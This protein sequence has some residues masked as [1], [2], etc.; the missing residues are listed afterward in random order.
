M[1]HTQK[2]TILV[3][4]DDP[5][6][7]EVLRYFLSC[8]GY[9]VR[10]AADFVEF[11]SLITSS[12]P[13]LVL[14]DLN[15]PDGDGLMCALSY[16]IKL[17]AS[18]PIIAITADDTPE[19][20]TRVFEAGADDYV[21][22]PIM[23]AELLARVQAQLKVSVLYKGLYAVLNDLDTGVL[24]IDNLGDVIF[25]NW[26]A[27]SILDTSKLPKNR[28][29][30]LL[31]KDIPQIH[32][33]LEWALNPESEKSQK[34]YTRMETAEN[35]KHLVIE[36]KRSRINLVGGASTMY[37][38]DQTELVS[39]MARLA[40][41]N[42]LLGTSHAMKQV[43]ES[44]VQLAQ[45][46]W[47]VLIFGETGVGKEL[48]AQAL[49]EQSHQSAGPF[50][51]VNCAGLSETLLQDQLFGH[52][53]GAFTGAMSTHKGFFEQASGGSLF[54][55]EIGDLPLTMQGSLLRVLQTQSFTR[56]GG[57]KEI[58]TNV[59][60]IFATNIKLE[61]KVKSGTFRADLFYRISGTTIR[62]PPLRER[63]NDVVIL[64]E[65][66]LSIYRFDASKPSPQMDESLK[67]WVVAQ[68]WPGNIRQLQ[69][70]AKQF[71]LMGK[72]LISL[73]DGVNAYGKEHM[74]PN[75]QKPNSLSGNMQQRE[76]QE[77]IAALERA[78]GDK[79]EAARILGISRATLYRKLKRLN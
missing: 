30:K 57:S 56:L 77:I 72:P 47:P 59:R 3:L 33:Q 19:S 67:D 54:L 64:L 29:W 34:I 23:E 28:S 25:A 35:E 32:A 66:Y 37:L 31:L 17:G 68:L 5:V 9:D 12:T 69:Q 76:N 1:K 41:Q 58:T 4:D 13:D 50:V 6:C 39:L 48:V 52:E 74:V 62:V 2:S 78:H 11:D 36:V 14:S 15:L 53:R 22:K 46:D 55:D 7:L 40:K 71:L 73:E 65:Y 61:E 16:K 38:Q 60:L 24:V 70:V 10:V 42:S 79:N 43:Q 51:T 8:S 21:P 20:I 63:Q 18:F 45:V 26:R 44:I 49:H 75:E 27:L